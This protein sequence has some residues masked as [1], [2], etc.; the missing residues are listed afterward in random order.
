MK[1]D[2]SLQEQIDAQMRDLYERALAGDMRAK[3]EWF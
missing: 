1:N 3:A 2:L